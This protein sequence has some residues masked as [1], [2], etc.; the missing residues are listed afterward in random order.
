[1]LRPLHGFL[2]APQIVRLLS[3]AN[4]QPKHQTTGINY[5]ALYH[6]SL[7]A[8]VQCIFNAV[9]L[10]RH[11]LKLIPDNHVLV[12]L[13]FSN[14]LNSIRRYLVFDSIADKMPELYYFLYSSCSSNSILTFESQVIRS[15]V[16]ISAVWSSQFPGFL[17]CHS[18]HSHHSQLWSSN[19]FHGWLFI[20]WVGVCCSRWC[21]DISPFCRRNRFIPQ[22]YQMRDYCK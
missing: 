12:K 18:S 3:N 4:F 19:Q 14:A 17:W 21:R 2:A 11:Y 20:I 9:C 8:T 6:H 7:C 1:M 10:P 15:K 22:C 13:N 5:T 16:R